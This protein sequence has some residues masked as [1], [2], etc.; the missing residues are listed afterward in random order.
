VNAVRSLS[1]LT[2]VI[3]CP[4]VHCEGLAFDHEYDDPSKNLHR[5]TGPELDDV[6]LSIDYVMIATTWPRWALSVDA[7]H[8][9]EETTPAEAALMALHLSRAA[10]QCS[11][12]TA[13]HIAAG[14]V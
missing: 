6:S 11:D 14:W 5:V 4:V 7:W 10:L 12:M 9:P 8:A 13:A 2:S 3:D 1:D